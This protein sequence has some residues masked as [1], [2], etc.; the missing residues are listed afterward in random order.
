MVENLACLG[1]PTGKTILLAEN[2]T[3][4]SNCVRRMLGREN[5]QVVPARC[6]EE[7]L[8]IWK[9]GKYQVDLLLTDLNM[10]GIGGLELAERLANDTKPLKTI[11]I[12]G[13]PDLIAEIGPRL[14]GYFMGKKDSR[15]LRV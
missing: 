9:Q 15:Y 3:L 11:F 13:H 7:A 1:E 5:F 2:D 8:D 12:S 10:P 4:A 14:A 6:G